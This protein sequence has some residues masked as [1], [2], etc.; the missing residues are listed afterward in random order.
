MYVILLESQNY[1]LKMLFAFVHNECIV[2]CNV[3]NKLKV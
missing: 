3:K 1:T 2:L